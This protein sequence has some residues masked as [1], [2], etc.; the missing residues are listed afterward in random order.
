[1][2]NPADVQPRLENRYRIR[3]VLFTDTAVRVGTKLAAASMTENPIA[4]DVWG[5]PFLPGSTL[6]GAIRMAVERLVPTLNLPGM[7]SCGFA[8]GSRVDCVSVQ[9]GRRREAQ[10]LADGALAEFLSEHTCD[11]CRLFG[12]PLQAGRVLFADLAAEPGW[13]AL[14]ELRDGAPIDRDTERAYE[15]RRFDFEVVPAGTPFRCEI[16]AENLSDPDLG[17]LA[18]GVLELVHGQVVLG[19]GKSR[20]LGRCH[21]EI[22]AVERVRFGPDYRAEVLAYAREGSM[23]DV[24]PA[25]PF[26]TER[27]DV[28]LS[29]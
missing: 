1:M 22:E 15:R 21:V 12:S 11:T 10:E 6:K 5:R 24:G 18:L 16:A 4:R 27:V 25:V 3:G 7:R 17:L 28:L 14:A 19:G 13:E 29:S 26:L 20:G 23:A 8:A 9:E 2:P